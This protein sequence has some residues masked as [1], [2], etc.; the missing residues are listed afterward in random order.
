[1]K[2]PIGPC[3]GRKCAAC[4]IACLSP[5]RSASRFEAAPLPTA[6]ESASEFV[7]SPAI[8]SVTPRSS[9]TS[10]FDFVTS[11]D[12]R[13]HRFASSGERMGRDGPVLVEAGYFERQSGG[14]EVVRKLVQLFHDR[15]ID[16]AGF[17]Q[18]DREVATL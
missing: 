8:I 5:A 6:S 18:I 9:D 14:L 3:A 17:R 10:P 12:R 15:V 16:E 7:R 11:C 1:M 13:R 2:T 4:S